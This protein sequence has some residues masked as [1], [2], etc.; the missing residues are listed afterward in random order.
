VI[1]FR[2]IR[3]LTG[4]AMA[5]TVVLILGMAVVGVSA[6]R[7]VTRQTVSEL[8]AVQEGTSLGSSLVSAVLSE[9]RLAE[10]YLLNPSPASG[11]IPGQWRL[12]VRSRA[13]ARLPLSSVEAA[14]QPGGRQPRRKG[15]LPLPTLAYIGRTDEACLVATGRWRNRQ[16]DRVVRQLTTNRRCTRFTRGAAAAGPSQPFV[17]CLL[18]SPSGSAPDWP[19]RVGT[20]P[21]G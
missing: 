21:G 18:A 3:Q 17:V 5:C 13:H 19:I 4:A 15:G 16:P 14:N 20:P 8:T 12:R 7:S 2:S 9:I 6:L 10:E 1:Q 11:T